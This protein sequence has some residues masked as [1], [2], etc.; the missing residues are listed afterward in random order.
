MVDF[1]DMNFEDAALF[2]GIMGFVEDSIRAEEAKEIDFNSSDFD[3]AIEDELQV[4]HNQRLLALYIQNPG[5][6]RFMIKE[7]I[8]R[9]SKAEVSFGQDEID[10]VN[11]EMREE[12]FGGKDES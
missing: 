6:V 8:K 5:L 2:G 9:R 1:G 4:N 3:E 10:K 12:L 7:F 11:A